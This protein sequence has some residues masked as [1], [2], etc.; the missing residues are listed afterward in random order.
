MQHSWKKV[1]VSEILLNIDVENIVRNVV[2]FSMTHKIEAW[3]KF[4][5]KQD[6]TAIW[7]TKCLILDSFLRS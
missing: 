6:W 7:F 3:P 2:S 1:H 4:V 5:L